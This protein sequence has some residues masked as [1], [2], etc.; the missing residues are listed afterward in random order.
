MG[1]DDLILS[2]RIE[3]RWRLMVAEEVTANGSGFPGSTCMAAIDVAHPVDLG[4]LIG[5]PGSAARSSGNRFARERSDANPASLAIDR[6][7][8]T[9]PGLCD[10]QIQPIDVAL[11]GPPIRWLNR[12]EKTVAWFKFAESAQLGL[13]D[14]GKKTPDR[15]FWRASAATRRTGGLS[16]LLTNY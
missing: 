6:A 9:L 8:R 2:R 12:R 11:G 13:V 16:V 15:S 3:P 7:G 4:T 1:N 5:R 10:F 14:I